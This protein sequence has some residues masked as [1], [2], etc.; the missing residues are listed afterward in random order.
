MN[1]EIVRS[2]AHDYTREYC[3]NMC[4][5]HLR[6]YHDRFHYTQAKIRNTCKI[7]RQE[8]DDG[9]FDSPIYYTPIIS[10]S[11]CVAIVDETNKVFYEVG[12]YSRTT[13][14]QITR[15]YNE[16]YSDYERV[17]IKD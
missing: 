16:L 8:F 13:S 5:Y 7:F 15:I 4:Q 9:T 12:K 11:T 3:Y 2:L 6:I 10:Y 1:K 14:K 17:F